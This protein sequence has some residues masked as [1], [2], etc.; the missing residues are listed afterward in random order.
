MPVTN[1]VIGNNALAVDAAGCEAE[2]LGYSHAM[3]AATAPEGP[4]EEVGRHLA[5]NGRRMRGET[6]PDCLDLRRR[7]DRET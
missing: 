5:A 3:I 7:T 4:A 1:L 6:G 2:R